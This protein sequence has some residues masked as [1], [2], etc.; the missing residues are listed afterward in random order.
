MEMEKCTM[1]FQSSL[2]LQKCSVAIENVNII[3]FLPW[4]GQYSA[5]IGIKAIFMKLF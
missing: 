2:C 4:D 1:D 3:W 5:K